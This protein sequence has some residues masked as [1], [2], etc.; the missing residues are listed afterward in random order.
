MKCSVE[1][2]FILLLFL[3]MSTILLFNL[4]FVLCI[5]ILQLSYKMWCQM[6]SVI[7][8]LVFIIVIILL[9]KEDFIRNKCGGGIVIENDDTRRLYNIS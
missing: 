4:F 2:K 9:T 7:I 6:I 1:N 5:S 3:Q 8:F